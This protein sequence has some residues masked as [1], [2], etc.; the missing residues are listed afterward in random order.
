MPDQDLNGISSCQDQGFS[1]SEARDRTE[2]TVY[3]SW[4]QLR[5]VHSAV[6]YEVTITKSTTGSGA[7]APPDDVWAQRKTTGSAHTQ[8]WPS[9]STTGLGTLI[10][11]KP[12]L[13]AFSESS[14]FSH[15]PSSDQSLLSLRRHGERGWELLAFQ[16]V[17]ESDSNKEEY[18]SRPHCRIHGTPTWKGG[19]GGWNDELTR[20]PLSSNFIRPHF[21][22]GE[23]Y[24]GHLNQ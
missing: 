10:F 4:R 13:A 20:I 3:W 9:I 1:S 16:A 19:R 17:S 8:S 11:S 14:G 21:T 23:K 5:S 12:M 18:D 2:W 24:Q 22:G 15:R 7:I 6:S